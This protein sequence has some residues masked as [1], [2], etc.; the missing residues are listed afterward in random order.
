MEER[1]ARAPDAAAGER[2][3][4]IL[5]YHTP[6]DELGDIA[7]RAGVGHLL[8]SHIIDGERPADELVDAARRGYSGRVTLGE[9]LM[10]VEVG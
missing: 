6:A 9:D 8:L 3:R 4:E 2:A 7:T 10:E 5:S 1:I